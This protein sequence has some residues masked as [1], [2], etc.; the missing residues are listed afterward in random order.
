MR[1]LLFVALVA[2]VSSVCLY[3]QKG[4]HKIEFGIN[5]SPK[6][7]FIIVEDAPTMLYKF[8]AYSEF[9]WALGRHFDTGARLDCK[10]GPIGPDSYCINDNALAI[11][12][13]LLAIIDYNILSGKAVN[14]FI[15]L[16]LGPG[17]GMHNN[18]VDKSWGGQFLI[19]ADARIGIELFRHLRL[20]VDFS[21]P[22]WRGEFPYF[23][24]LNANIGWVF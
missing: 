14:P 23:T 1:R 2:L 19:Y 7:N 24:T 9:R 18:A 22:Y 13:D 12:G 11:S 20:S 8:G 4:G 10:V 15:G 21:V 16:G 17:F 5:Y 3:G 6:E